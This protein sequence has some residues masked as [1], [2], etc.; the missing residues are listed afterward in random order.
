MVPLVSHP[1]SNISACGLE[2]LHPRRPL[3]PALP[4]LLPDP[5]P[6]GALPCSFAAG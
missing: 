4:L 1:G 2:R 6:H 5:L 3:P